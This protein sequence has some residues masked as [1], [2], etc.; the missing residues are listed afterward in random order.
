M[1]RIRII[2]V[3]LTISFL[4]T[5]PL[6]AA[7]LPKVKLFTTGG[8]IQG[9]G[10]NRQNIANYKAGQITPKQLLDDL[11]EVKEIADVTYLE[12][13]AIGSGGIDTKILLTLAKEIN[14]WLARPE[15]AGAVVTHGTATMEETAYFL[16]LTIHSDKPIVVVGAM[17]PFTRVSRD[18]PF[19]LY[20]SIRVAALKEA[21]GKGVMILLNDEINAARDVTKTNTYRVNTFESRDLGPIGFADSDRI[22]FYRNNLYKH[23]YKSEFDVSNLTSL[24]KVDIVYGYQ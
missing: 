21:K 10:D 13:S 20:N 3:L 18:A 9:F 2:L 15:A 19:N 6:Q 17:R 8:T 4:R 12:I 14:A 22:V 5:S 7:D 1:K 24:P 23:T 16:N 11:P